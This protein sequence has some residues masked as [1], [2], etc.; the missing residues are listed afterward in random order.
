[1]VFHFLRNTHAVDSSDNNSVSSNLSHFNYDDSNSESDISIVNNGN[2]S[3]G[4]F[5]KPE[6]NEEELK[7]RTFSSDGENESNDRE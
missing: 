1:M 2:F 3:C 7:S 4:F 6:Y 5:G